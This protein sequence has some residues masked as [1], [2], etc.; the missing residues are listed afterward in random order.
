MALVIKD[1]VKESTQ[2]TGVGAYSLAG[3]EDGFQTFATIGDGNKTYYAVTDGTDWEVGVGTYTASGATLSR[4]EILSS[5]N[6]DAAVDWQAGEKLI[7]VT[8]PAD[9]ANL[10][11]DSGDA[12]GSSFETHID[13]KTTVA[14]KPSHSEGRLFYDKGNGALAFYNDE[15][16]ITL[17]IGQEEYIRVYNNTGATVSNGTPVYL[18][19]QSSGFPTIAAAIAG[20]TFIQSQAVGFA[21]HDIE[22]ATVGYVTTRGLIGDLDTSSLMVGKKVHVGVSGGV[23]TDSPTYP[24]HPTEVGICLVSDASNGVIYVD[25]N[26]ESFQTLRVDGNAHFDAGVIVNGDLTINGTQTITSTNNISLANAWNYFNGGNTITSINFSGTGVDDMTFTGHY[27]GTASSRTFYVRI[28]DDQSA[29]DE[30]EWSL[31]NFNTIEATGIAITGG[32]QLLQDGVSVRFNAT[33]GHDLGDTWDGTASP[34]NVD[35]G[36]AS[37]RNTGTSG[38]G[39][40]HVG[41][42]YDVSTGHWTAFDEYSPEPEATIDTDHESFSYGTFKAEGFYGSLI[43]NA[44]TATAA[45]ALSTPRNISLSGDVSGSVSFDGST[46]VNITAT[47]ANDS[48]THDT[49]YVKLGGSTMTGTLGVTEVDFGDWTITESGGSLYFAHSGTNKMKLDSDGNLSVA[50][51]VN[52]EQGTIS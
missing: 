26:H 15:S 3:A 22:D 50:G 42:F 18:V 27:K 8:Q 10:L 11:D 14:N 20:G 47:V 36:I 51:Y 16:D 17:Q 46:N 25:V 48:H 9:K 52:A 35:T 2:T 19:G 4:T 49:Q 23:Q 40:T 7:F 12:T 21:T 43:G 1:R 34:T 13:L 44:D 31:D 32:D 41:F 5:S 45:E 28:S 6:S 37:N 33:N 30:F 39:Y 24:N 29:P 38:I